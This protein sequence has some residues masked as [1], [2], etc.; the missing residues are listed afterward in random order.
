MVRQSLEITLRP[1]VKGFWTQKLSRSIGSALP[2]LEQ[3]WTSCRRAVGNAV[4]P[5]E[6]RDPRP[7]HT[8]GT[9]IGSAVTGAVHHA[10]DLVEQVING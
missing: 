2:M 5:T 10:D 8:E 4:G 9:S 6:Q 7:L 3:G 1:S